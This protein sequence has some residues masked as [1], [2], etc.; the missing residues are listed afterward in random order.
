MSFTTCET[1]MF[2]LRHYTLRLKR[3]PADP[4]YAGKLVE[5]LGRVD[6][7]K[8]RGRATGNRKIF[9]RRGP[10]LKTTW[11]LANSTINDGD[12]GGNGS[13]SNNEAHIENIGS[14]EE[15]NANNTVSEDHV[16]VEMSQGATG[17]SHHTGVMGQINPNPSHPVPINI[18]D[19]SNL[20]LG[21]SI[22]FGMAQN[23]NEWYN[24]KVDRV[25]QSMENHVRRISGQMNGQM[26]HESTGTEHHAPRSHQPVPFM[27][28][29]QV[30]NDVPNQIPNRNID[31]MVTLIEKM[32]ENQTQMQAMQQ[33][34][35]QLLQNSM[36]QPNQRARSSRQGS[37]SEAPSAGF[38]SFN[39]SDER[40]YNRRR[41]EVR[42]P[43]RESSSGSDSSHRRVRH[44]RRR[45]TNP[46]QWP[47]VFSGSLTG[48]SGEAKS[49]YNK[50]KSPHGSS[51][52]SE[53][54]SK[55]DMVGC[56]NT[57][58]VGTAQKWWESVGIEL[59]FIESTPV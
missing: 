24:R 50:D 44:N 41:T 3:I 47:F 34:T 46:A 38:Q 30:E 22:N 45:A 8:R 55:S 58:L 28:A 43:Q 11:A 39:S 36:N 21:N 17:Y 57:L 26:V 14:H 4:L 31:P 5:L 49:T 27:S 20:N 59:R 25:T 6:R 18:D 1:L 12:M 29:R 23:Q 42:R 52:I 13:G 32:V 15:P 9:Q 35:Y 37:G 56:M 40:E 2:R 19:F 53:K 10:H 54:L 16:N 48:A 51:R 33:A 7:V